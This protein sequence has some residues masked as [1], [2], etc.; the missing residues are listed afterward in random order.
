MDKRV[1]WILFLVTSFT[2]AQTTVTLEDQCNCEV[3]Q[4]TDV[5]APGVTTPS[6]ADLGD[7]YVNTTTGTI[8][9]WDGDSWELTTATN[10]D[11]QQ[12]QNFTFETATNILSL[13]LQNGGTVIVDLSDLQDTSVDTNTTNDRI[14]VVGP[15]LVITDSDNNIISIPLADIASQ[16]DTNTTITSFAIDGSN[17]NL[18]LTDSD[19][20]SFSIAIADIANLVNS[21]NQNL[22]N[23]QVNGANL[24]LGIVDGNVVSVPLADI[25]AGVNTDDQTLSEVL[26]EG[27][28]A[29]GTVITNLGTPVAGTDAVTKDYVDGL[30]DDDISAVAFDGTNLSVTESGTTLSADISALDDSAGVATNASDIA[31]NTTNIATN[32]GDISTNAGNITTN[33]TDI[34]NHIANDND[35]DDQNE[36]QNLGE[37]LTEGADAGGTVITNLGTPVAAGDAVTKAYVDGLADD[38]IS[39]VTF[40]GTNLSVTESGTTLSADISAL[41]DSAGVAT[42]ASN[43]ATNTGD[44]STNA[45]NIATNAGNIAINTTNIGTNATDI[46]NHIANDNDTDLTN[47]LSQVDAGTPASTGATA[48]NIGETYVDTNTGQLYVWDGAVWTQVGGNASPDADPDPLNEIQNIEEVLAD[49]ND[50]NGAVIT[51]LGTPTLGSDAATKTYV[52]TQIA[53]SADDDIT[54]A[55]L[56]APSNVLTIREGA[57]D[58]TVNL[59]DLDDSAGVATNAS[60]IATNTTNIATNAGDISTNAGNITTNA[61]DI[62]N[63]I[64]NDNDTDD[65]NEIQNL[66]EVLTEGADAGGTVITNL[67]TPVAAGD[68]V[69]K[70]YV[71]GLADDDISAVAFDGTN[72]SVTESGTT[73]SADISA[74]DDSAGVATNASDIATNTTNIATNAGNITTNATDIANHIAAD[75]DTDDTNEIQDA[76]GVDF[77]AAGNT[78]S[79]NV[80]DA[81]EEIQTE[82]D[83]VDGTD[84]QNLEN[85]QVNGVN[86]E[87]SIQDGNTVSVPLVDIDTDNQTASEVSVAD[88]GG[89]F[90]NNEVEGVLEEI[91][92]RID[93]LVLAGGSDG[94]DFVT[95]GTLSGTDLTLNVPNQVD[96]VIDLSG[97]QDGTGTDDQT[98]SEVLAEGADAGGT[99]ITSAVAFDGTNLSVTESG[100]TLSADISALDD[101]AGVATNASN[102]A[103]N[104]TN[105]ATN[106]GDISTNAGNITTNATDIANHIANDNDTDDQNE[107]QNLGEVLT[108]GAD[109]GGTV[110]TNLGTPVAGTDAVTKDYVDGLADDDISAVAFDGTNLS[111]TESGTTLSADISALDDSAGVATNASNIATNTTNITANTNDITNLQNDKEDAA[112]KSTDGTLAGNSNTDFPTEQAVKT[113]VDTQIT[114]NNTVVTAGNDISVTGDGSSAT[115]YVV[116]NTRPN[117]FYP[118]S[119]AI[120]VSAYSGTPILNQT[121]NLH[122][123]YIAQYGSPMVR[124]DVGGGDEAPNAIPTYASGDLY[125]YVTFFDNTVF[126]NVEIDA[127]GE[128]EYDIIGAPAD[129]NSLINVVFVVK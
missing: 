59:S 91:D 38:D 112:N 103:T 124:S 49:G 64:A 4:G 13:D 35:T 21:D 7:L 60:D 114:A 100:T 80:Q 27:A 46:A 108:E 126:A 119:I 9:F 50:A 43:I 2:F 28:D 31:T 88:V 79:T 109:A 19:S 115:P 74:L 47:E 45:G 72:L 125:Y 65:Q 82:L 66:G 118:P 63:H 56:D 128:M 24:E 77:T 22:E 95:G 89:N 25:T 41:D 20:N 53:A 23:F 117:I 14:E 69:T 16:V 84:D 111:V 29:G 61:T 37:V 44:I 42:N 58:V 52:D 87:I 3:I 48:S 67:G 76:V 75:G 86:L 18:V 11:N 90:T 73:L 33:A 85:F 5:S 120:D 55:S 99:V 104:T 1:L 98:L 105:I 83:G 127:D 12:L 71:D 106:A 57:T 97:L 113:Y 68:A 54:G 30:A 15:N 110:I 6:G 81:I 17:T 62:A 102:I 96:P 39:A 122:A 78:T 129:Y 123:Q 93:A 101:S 26:G 121:I 107:I 70:A 8:F 36:I 32:A 92:S 116:A 40:D 10:T 34:A 51:G 94:N